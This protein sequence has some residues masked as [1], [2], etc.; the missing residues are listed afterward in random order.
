MAS[1]P[2]PA[3]LSDLQRFLG[4]RQ[5]R[6]IASGV[7]VQLKLSD[8]QGHQALET[9]DGLNDQGAAVASGTYKHRAR[10]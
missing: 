3:G 7:G 4:G 9:W 5:R 8:S 6:V 10:P 2:L 1:L